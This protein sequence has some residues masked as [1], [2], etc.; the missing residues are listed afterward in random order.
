MVD[1]EDQSF[2]RRDERKQVRCQ[3]LWFEFAAARKDHEEG[4]GVGSSGCF[5]EGERRKFISD[6]LYM[7][8]GHTH[9]SVMAASCF[10]W[11]FLRIWGAHV[12]AVRMF[13]AED[14]RQS[15]RDSCREKVPVVVKPSGSRQFSR[16]E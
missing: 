11:K 1:E 3:R 2:A 15:D 9:L 8:V 13:K 10:F 12:V 14:M 16:P 4:R 7:K 5:W 6:F